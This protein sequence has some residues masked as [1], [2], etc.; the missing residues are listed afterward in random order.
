[1]SERLLQGVPASPG[2]ALGAAWRRSDHTPATRVVPVVPVAQRSRERERALEALDAAATELDAIAAR[3]PAEEGEIVRA[4]ALMARDPALAG[5]VESAVL[6]RGLAGAEAILEATGTHAA[7]IA[8]LG[9]ETLAAR[10]DDVRSLGRRAARLAADVGSGEVAPGEVSATGTSPRAPT[11]LIADDLGPADVAELSSALGG[12]VLVGGGATAHAAIVARSLGL[13]MI[14]GLDATVLAIPDGTPLALDG[15]DGSLAVEPSVERTQASAAAM[16]TRLRAAERAGAE[17]DL[18]SVT[19][20]GRRVSVLVNVA[21]APE[22]EVGLRAGA[23]GIGLLRTELAFLDARDWPT[24]S[25]HLDSLEPILATLGDRPATVRVLDFGADKAPPFLRGSTRRGLE[26]LL[27][28]RDAFVRQLRAILLAAHGR[29]VRILLPMVDSQAQ[30]VAA[31]RV[32]EH[33]ARALGVT[34]VPPVGA[35]IETPAAARA[36][37]ALAIRADF[38][39]IGT[40]DLTAATLGADRF[41]ANQARAHDPRVLALIAQSVAAAHEAGICIEVCGEAA[42]DPLTLPLLVGLGVDE[43]SVGA[44]R[45]GTVRRWIRGLSQVEVHELAEA[46]LAMSEAVEVETAVRPLAR[47]LESAEGGHAADQ[48]LERNGRVLALGP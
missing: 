42:S 44:A 4:G 12:V 38:L 18:P 6:E 21:G 1:M 40:N 34:A 7:V 30:L 13:P 24:E 43:V 32:L 8:A 2:V 3:L 5:A 45:V 20:D 10:A 26:L 35:M 36:A 17:C 48:G 31:R 16:G 14:T 41:A 29:D 23:E 27:V 47:R 22:L 9:D 46:A 33:T 15:S 28:H 11:I 19:R 25:E 37:R 39:S